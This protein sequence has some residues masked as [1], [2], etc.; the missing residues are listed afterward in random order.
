MFRSHNIIDDDE[1]VTKFKECYELIMD[2]HKVTEKLGMKNENGSQGE[3]NK[4]MNVIGNDPNVKSM[5]EKFPP[6]TLLSEEVIKL[7][8]NLQ[9]LLTIDKKHLFSFAQNVSQL[10]KF[11]CSYCISS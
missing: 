11:E 7:S 1:K 6:R 9:I 5:L 10:K 3:E 2:A 4:C 8:Y